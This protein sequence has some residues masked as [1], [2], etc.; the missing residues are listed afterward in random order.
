MPCLRLA[1]GISV[2]SSDRCG[3]HS[4]SAQVQ[5]P[6]ID[7]LCAIGGKWTRKLN[8]SNLDRVFKRDSDMAIFTVITVWALGSFLLALLLGRVFRLSAN[9]GHL[10]GLEPRLHGPRPVIDPMPRLLG[11]DASKALISS[12]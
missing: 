6:S 8:R 12:Y 9:R 5:T 7:A 4:I 10:E 3:R 2:S 1:P 11:G